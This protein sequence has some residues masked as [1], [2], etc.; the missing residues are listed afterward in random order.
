MFWWRQQVDDGLWVGFT[1]VTAG[2][3]SVQDD[4][5][6]GSANRARLA[7]EIGVAPGA[8]R[9]MRQV[10][11]TRVH[12]ITASPH[13]EPEPE[14]EADGLIAADGRTPLAVLTAD[15]LPVILAGRR[16]VGHPDG[17]FVTAAVH[18]GRRGL[19]DGVLR[20]CVDGMQALGAF[21]I[22]AWIGP[23]ICGRC[24]EVPEDMRQDAARHM[25]GISSVTSWETPALD[26]TAAAA[27]QLTAGGVRCD[28]IPG[29]T[30]EVDSLYSYRRDADCGRMAGVVWQ[31]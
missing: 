29:C 3:L 22:R 31:R 16:S 20:A 14:P 7:A 11:S 30:R 9:F 5:A 8:L 13:T 1:D 12:T 10:H 25:P 4:H 17:R 27:R 2:S 15:C 24:Y 26:L 23:G 28:V 6:A 21:E 19:L 18:A